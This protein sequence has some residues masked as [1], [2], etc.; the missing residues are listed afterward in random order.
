METLMHIF[1]E[2]IDDVQQTPS[3]ENLII[4]HIIEG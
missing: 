1:E 3:F 2:E 4:P